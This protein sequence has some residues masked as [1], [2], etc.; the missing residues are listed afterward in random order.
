MNI[1]CIYEDNS[2]EKSLKEK[3]L[4]N[5]YKLAKR[6]EINQII[7][8]R[9]KNIAINKIMIG[10]PQ[11]KKDKIDKKLIENL[12]YILKEKGI[13][14]IILSNDLYN[15]ETM[16]NWLYAYNYNI[17]N[18]RLLMKTSIIDII[19]YIMNNTNSNIN[20]EEIAIL[21]NDN[22]NINLEIIR[23]IASRAKRVNIVTNNIS[24]FRKL[25]SKLYEESGIILSIGNNRKKGLT[26]S[27]YIINIDFPEELLNKYRMYKK[28]ILVNI[29]NECKINTKLFS[30]III[31]DIK[32]KYNDIIQKEKDIYKEFSENKIYEAK[33]IALDSLKEVISIK[34]EDKYKIV[35][36]I[37]NNGI[38]HQNEFISAKSKDGEN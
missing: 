34:K 20:T 4:K 36:T 9:Y 11:Y 33:I 2:D 30:G 38:I 10:I 1:G 24:R 32:I 3:I 17:L 31:N 21:V 25:E 22:S 6:A 13:K 14:N 12:V 35:N 7:N 8:D 5:Y 37:G 29:E 16:K 28:A 15:K 26:R 18:G 19:E 23:E 27:K